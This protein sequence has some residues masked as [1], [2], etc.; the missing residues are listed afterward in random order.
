MPYQR[1]TNLIYGACLDS[2]FSKSSGRFNGGV[3]GLLEHLIECKGEDVE[4]SKQFI[5]GL[6]KVDPAFRSKF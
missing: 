4:S 6:I 2:H 1:Y 3:R 5:A